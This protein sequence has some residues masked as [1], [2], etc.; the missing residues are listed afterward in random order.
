MAEELIGRLHRVPDR[1]FFLFGPRAIGKSVWLRQSLPQARYFDLLDHSLYLELSGSPHRLESLVGK[2]ARGTWVALDEIQKI[3]VLLDEVHRL[4][5]SRGWRFA[6]CGSSARKLR[7]GGV[8]LL[9][10]RAITLEMEPFV[11]AELKDR[12][13]LKAALQWGCLPFV[14]DEPEQAPEILAA[15]LNTYIKEEIREEGLVR[16]VPPFLRFL[17]ITG[18]ING[19]ILNAQNI[20]R[21]AAV[22]RSSVEVYFSIL[23]DTL[24]GHFLPA[25]QPRLKVRETAHPK[26]FWFDPGVARAAAGLLHDP[27]DRTW[28]GCALETLVFHELRVFNQIRGKHRM[29]SYYRT[30]A[31]TEID[32]IIE[33]GKAQGNSPPRVVCV[34]V[35]L[36]E[37]WDRRWER[38]MRDLKG[39]KRIRV[40]RMFGVYTGPRRYHF[41]GVEVMPVQDFL[42]ALH[43]G[44]VF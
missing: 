17:G 42:N 2:A 33:T 35:K 36:S 23:G 31:G 15:Y 8:N 10:G 29:I 9:A 7:R 43:A 22:P 32:F 44:L 38:A 11:S 20:A 24:L 13:D 1:S 41:D 26:F 40:D 39:Q 28:L 18:Q 5:E 14:V 34:E 30:M 25:W 27:P 16:K 12:F 3:P 37:K 21:E 6:L 19:Q 4:M